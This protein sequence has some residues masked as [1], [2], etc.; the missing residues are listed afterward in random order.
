M[1][2]FTLLVILFQT[3]P[4]WTS[5]LAYKF[6]N[7]PLY[8]VEVIGMI[9]CFVAVVFITIDENDSK[10]KILSTTTGTADD[11]D[12]EKIVS[13]QNFLIKTTGVFLILFASLMSASIAVLNRSL[14]EV[15][16]SVV[17]FYHSL[18]GMTATV[19]I[20]FVGKLIFG[21]PLYFL[22]LAR[23][24]FGILALASLLDA[25]GVLAQTVAY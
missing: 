11:L 5:I 8:K 24:D 6:N 25:I 10:E 2:P 19:A 4:F 18:L 21:R 23:L 3:S 15:P 13:N 7:E 17:L 12:L 20:L 16:Y 22:S 14:R 1:I 9:L